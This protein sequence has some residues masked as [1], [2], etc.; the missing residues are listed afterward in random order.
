MFNTAVLDGSG[1]AGRPHRLCATRGQQQLD[2]RYARPHWDVRPSADGATCTSR[3]SEARAGKNPG[4]RLWDMV[5][6][7]LCRGD[8]WSTLRVAGWGVGVG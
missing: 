5:A 1:R 6:L 8:A 3:P 2:S 7:A 4:T